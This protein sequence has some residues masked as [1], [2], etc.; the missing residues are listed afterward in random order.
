M[1]N[2][3]FTIIFFSLSFGITSFEFPTHP[4]NLGK[5][6]GGTAITSTHQQANPASLKMA[7]S[8][9]LTTIR[10]PENINS[11]N[12][13][14]SKL[15]QN[16]VFNIKT[17]IID[18]GELSD[19]ITQNQFSAKDLIIGFSIKTIFKNL[20]SIGLSFDYL[21]SKIDIWNQ[22]SFK[23]T[24]GLLTH[25]MDKR[26]GVGITFIDYFHFNEIK[27]TW[28][29]PKLILG[30][31]YKPLH[32]PGT[33]ALDLIKKSKW[34]GILSLEINLNKYMLATIGINSDKFNF[35]SGSIFNNIFYGLS[36][37]ISV[38]WNKYNMSFGIR[39]LGQYGSITGLN[40]GKDI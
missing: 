28:G 5:W 37:G 25:L 8:I 4:M 34:E 17:S 40:I 12:F 1:N 9:S 16:Y 7:S 15:Y 35:H 36:S 29:Q 27:N 19:F 21:N 22:K 3:L 13:E 38:N 11:Q 33:V 14:T 24:F 31:F 23:G 6:N 39:N 2:H 18:Y 32:F 30:S 26:I 10:I 20:I